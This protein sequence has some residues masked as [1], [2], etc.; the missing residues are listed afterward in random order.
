MRKLYSCSQAFMKPYIITHYNV[1]PAVSNGNIR[2]SCLRGEQAYYNSKVQNNAL[3][4]R[5]TST[6][7][8][9]SLQH[10]KVNLQKNLSLEHRSN[11]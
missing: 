9:V 7:G 1:S 10:K 6:P 3:L 11:I 2:D 8:T 5:R 4:I